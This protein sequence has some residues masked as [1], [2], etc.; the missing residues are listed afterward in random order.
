MQTKINDDNGDELPY[1]DAEQKRLHGNQE[2]KARRF[3]EL[4]LV[5]TTEFSSIFK[6]LPIE[7]YNSTTYTIEEHAGVYRC[8]CQFG[9]SGKT[10]SHVLAVELFKKKD[11]IK[12]GGLRA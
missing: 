9:A 4:N 3:V 8:N 12:F 6:I 11:R 1:W 2:Y 5:K 10:C 7:G